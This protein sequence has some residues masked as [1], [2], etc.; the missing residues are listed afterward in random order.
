MSLLPGELKPVSE[1]DL[2]SVLADSLYAGYL[3]T[4]KAAIARLY[5]HDALK[6]P[7]QTAFAASAVSQTRSS[8]DLIALGL[9][10]RRSPP[11]S[12]PDAWR[13]LD[14]TRCIL[15][16]NNETKSQAMFHVSHSLHVNGTRETFKQESCVAR[17]PVLC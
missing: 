10:F 1:S 15:S 14:A 16:P 13:P 3:E 9:D 2:N 5:Q 8:S 6:I 11:S 17:F 4:Q 12:R 7:R